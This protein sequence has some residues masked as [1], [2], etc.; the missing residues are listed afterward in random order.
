MS[1]LSFLPHLNA[2][3]NLLSTGL[4]LAGFILIRRG[5]VAAHR[6][7]MLG[8]VTASAL[9]LVC[10]LVYHYGAGRTVFRDPA[11]FR[12]I[13]LGILLSHT[14]LAVVIVPLVAGTLR[15]ALGERFE[16]HKRLARWTWPLWIYVSA[17]GVVIY[18]LLYHIFP[19]P[20]PSA[21]SDL[22]TVSGQPFGDFGGHS[23]A[24]WPTTWD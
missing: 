7:C 24:A 3:L 23:E 20:Q 22:P 6:A 12:P 21:P 17:T 13:Y 1:G 18:A 9:F 19:Q 10:Y 11:W 5:Q 16:R 2:G 15:F 14:V 4:L 8:A